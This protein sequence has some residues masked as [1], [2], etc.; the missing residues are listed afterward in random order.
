MTQVRL[1]SIFDLHYGNSFELN[2]LKRTFVGVNFVSRTAKNNGISA[3]VKR[4]PDI[5][6]FPAGLITVSL[7]GSVLETFVQPESFYTGYHIFCLT[8]KIEMSIEQK[9]YYC[10]CISANKYRYNYGRQ[11]NRSLKT[12]LIPA[13]DSV[14]SF[15]KSIDLNEFDG[16]ENP[17]IDKNINLEIDNWKWFEYDLLF[18]IERGRGPRKKELDGSGRIPFVTST[19]QNNGWTNFTKALPVHL[20]N[21]IGV[22]RNGSVAEAFYQPEPFCSTE[23]VH[24]FTP[25]FP[26]TKYSALFIATLIKKEKYRYNYGRKWG[27]ARM[28]SS[29]IKLPVTNEGTPD[30]QF[31]E[32]FMKSLRFSKSI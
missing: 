12:L 6:P 18:K 10:T 14:P 29:K 17:L 28:K 24:I 13:L 21:T 25:K 32:D 9:L 27:L 15:I 7:G 23:D 30:F 26:M 1:D 2:N 19:D 16:L 31:M 3:K 5:D 4:I 8:P 11:A 20:S 22:N